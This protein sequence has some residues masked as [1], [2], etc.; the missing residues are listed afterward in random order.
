MLRAFFFP[1]ILVKRRGPLQSPH[2]RRRGGVIA[3]EAARIQELVGVGDS[4]YI[5]DDNVYAER[6]ILISNV[7]YQH[8]GN[9][10]LDTQQESVL[11][12]Y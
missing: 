8:S 3:V 7:N 1:H 12:Y 5:A 9:T 10:P 2:Q 11:I 4:P 6:V